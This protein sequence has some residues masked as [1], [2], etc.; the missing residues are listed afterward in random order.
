MT[1][2]IERENVEEL[3]KWGMGLEK[4]VEGCHF[5]GRQ[6]RDWHS[7]T[8]TPVCEGCASTHK[9]EDIKRSNAEL[10]GAS[11]DFAAKRPR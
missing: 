4:I 8:N 3:K 11:G 7:R 10:T 1:I 9:V 2:P 5:C 6:T